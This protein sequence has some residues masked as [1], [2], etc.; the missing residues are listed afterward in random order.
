AAAV[1]AGDVAGA[2]ELALHVVQLDA[3]TGD[4][5]V[6]ADGQRQGD[7]LADDLGVGEQHHRILAFVV[8]DEI[9]HAAVLEID[10]ADRLRVEDSLVEA[11]RLGRVL[12]GAVAF[13]AVIAVAA[14][15]AADDE[16]E[17]AVVSDIAPGGAR[18][19]AGEFGEITR[20][21]GD[22]GEAPLA[23]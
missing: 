8:E 3:A 21:H 14:F 22:I 15:Q 2:D 5:G 4:A 9:E 12:E 17:M 20:L 10:Q 16:I 19:P 6:A 23:I 7:A 1:A 13:I 18:G 11:D